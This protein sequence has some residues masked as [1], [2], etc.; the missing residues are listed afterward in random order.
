MDELLSRKAEE[1]ANERREMF[2][3]VDRFVHTVDDYRQQFA[4]LRKQGEREI[5]AL[6][7]QHQ[8]QL[9]KLTNSQRKQME[10]QKE[11]NRREVE[12]IQKEMDHCRQDAVTQEKDA[13]R[14]A[15]TLLQ[16]ESGLFSQYEGKNRTIL[17][18][19]I[20]RNDALER[21]FQNTD[22]LLGKTWRKKS[23]LLAIT[24]KKDYV[25]TVRNNDDAREALSSQA[26]QTAQDLY[27]SIEKICRNP[28][29]LIFFWR[30]RNQYCLKLYQMRIDGQ[31]ALELAKRGLAREKAELNTQFQ[32]KNNAIK[33]THSSESNRIIKERDENL[34]VLH[35]K[36]DLAE[37]EGADR[38]EK[39]KVS[40]AAA[41]KSQTEFLD[42]QLTR[43]RDQW[44]DTLQQCNHDFIVHMNNEYPANR[45]QAWMEQLWKY[46]KRVEKYPKLDEA[47]MNV[48]IGEAHL[49]ISEWLTGVTGKFLTGYLTKI[50][51]FLFEKDTLKLPYTLSLEE[52]DSLLLSYP[53]QEEERVRTM[54][55]A[56][57]IRLLRSVPATQMR[58]HLMDAYG[59]GTFDRIASIDPA[60]KNI[61]SEPIVKS[62]LMG[63]RVRNNERDIQAQISEI[64]VQMDSI[65]SGTTGCASLREFNVKNP[66]SRHIYQPIIMM[67]FPLGLKEEHIR[68]LTAMS[69]QSKRQGFSMYLAAP[70][71]YLNKVKPEMKMEI[72]SL[73]NAMLCL[74]LEGQII[75]VQNASSVSEQNADIYLY[76]LP[77][78]DQMR[79]VAQ[80]VRE[81]SVQASTVR[82]EFTKAKEICPDRQTWFK[83]SSESGV[84]IP[85]GY[86]ENGLPF[87]IVFDDNHV[88][89]VVA[90]ST[91]KG[92]S[93]LLHVMMTSVMLS[94]P[95]DEVELYLIDFKHG[96]D[97][98]IYTRYNLPNFHA[99]SITDD[100]SFALAMLEYIEKEIRIRSTNMGTIQKIDEYNRKNPS[101]RIS[102]IF[103]FVD[104]LY[105]LIKQADDET[106]RLILRKLD[107]FAHQNRAFGIHMV[108]SGQDL[109]MISG[110]ENILMECLTRVA[111]YCSDEQITA[112]F[113]EDGQT[114]MHALDENDRGVCVFSLSNT[115]KPQIGRTAYLSNE[116]QES[117]LSEISQYYQDCGILS[118][119]RILITNVNE[120][121]GHP[122][123]RF[124]CGDSIPSVKEL[125]VGEAVSMERRMNLMPVDNLWLCGGLGTGMRDEAGRAGYS[126]VFFA[127][128][129]LF[130]QKNSLQTEM[131]IICTNCGDYPGRHY[132]DA[133]IDRLSQLAAH[134]PHLFDYQRSGSIRTVLNQLLDELSQR[135]NGRNAPTIWWLLC[136]PE[137]ERNL[138]S[139]IATDIHELLREGPRYG[140]RTIIWTRS[141]NDASAFQFHQNVQMFSE[142]I[143]LEMPT[144]D[145]KLLSREQTMM[146]K[147]YKALYVG[148]N[149]MY[150]RIYDLPEDE[151]MEML[152]QRLTN[153][154]TD[155]TGS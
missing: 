6:Q 63:E 20:S 11:Q 153:N 2:A 16:K 9:A 66:L 107:N 79:K 94:Y 84:V 108:I 119:A 68:N 13:S 59:V 150:I 112:F 15:D 121:P 97:F 95:P 10:N 111:M 64:K 114:L 99:I 147:G 52:G 18:A 154:F 50:Y 115:N 139:S 45:V 120:D 131:Q 40:L 78:D 128:L 142:K 126:C 58:F 109:N 141:L 1:L 5:V 100:P 103:L 118:Q 12:R 134:F 144:E 106:Q 4:A 137:A 124:V 36:L 71:K 60:K 19:Y 86:L 129:S 151:W 117:I 123:Q 70:D 85:V 26:I 62:I 125:L 30:R 133:Q 87:K 138:N 46:P 29:K 56:L 98:R 25:S 49:K 130:L 113:K 51:P 33:K 101:A 53:D 83:S 31:T 21:C 145:L 17:N 48:L 143:Y 28:F 41:Y 27:H 116:A 7:Q 149:S 75:R 146:P 24:G 74:R 105:E 104:E 122:I 81:E 47:Y 90:G 127:F 65:S 69:T 8:E 35:Q 38:I 23:K 44:N 152:Y 54:M 73:R 3:F 80:Q 82:I 61:P 91:G 55:N 135:Q 132:D 37:K 42:Q 136:Q 57:G 32:Q 88:H 110:F 93:N 39:L 148:G 140:I 34:Q 77:Q 43:A 76:P 96:V 14:R 89:S 72:D 67:N 102:R 92:K 155:K 22:E